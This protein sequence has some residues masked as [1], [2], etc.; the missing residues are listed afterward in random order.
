MKYAQTFDMIH[1][2]YF[3]LIVKTTDYSAIMIR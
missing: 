1:F 2:F 3:L